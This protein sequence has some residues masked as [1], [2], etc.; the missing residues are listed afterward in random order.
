MY[1]RQ[2]MQVWNEWVEEKCFH[3][4]W[5]VSEKFS[6]EN[7]GL[8]ESTLVHIPMACVDLSENNVSIKLSFWR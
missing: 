5:K 2:R 3:L 7:F 1:A 8:M 6:T 4:T